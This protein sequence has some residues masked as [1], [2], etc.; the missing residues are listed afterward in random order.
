MFVMIKRKFLSAFLWRNM[1]HQ[2][3]LLRTSSDL[4][5]SKILP[6]TWTD[7]AQSRDT[8][9]TSDALA[10]GNADV[11]VIEDDGDDVFDGDVSGEEEGG[12]KKKRRVLFSKAQTFE[13]ERRFRQQRYLS[14]PE[15]EHLASMLHL[16]PTQVKIWFQ[17]HRYKLK[18]S[19]QEKGLDVTPLPAPRRVAVPVLIRDGKPC[20]APGVGTCIL[21]ASS[22]VMN[23]HHNA[24]VMAALSAT[25]PR[26]L[27]PQVLTALLAAS[28]LGHVAPG[29]QGLVTS[30]PSSGANA[31]LQLLN[32][33]H[34]HSLLPAPPR[35]W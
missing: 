2:Q 12:K 13:L 3:H 16:S 17:N 31:S 28:S 24:V 7:T 23:M 30:R 11:D 21:P 10:C 34:L 29:L 22:D 4:Q 20:S 14:A 6:Q 25:S 32:A 18:K 15:R 5:T 8:D 33:T 27:H 19:R 9:V 1:L 35:W 26:D